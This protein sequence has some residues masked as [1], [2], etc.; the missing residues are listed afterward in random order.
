MGC[1]A[2]RVRT[3]FRSGGYD[4]RSRWIEIVVLIAGL[5]LLLAFAF[6]SQNGSLSVYST[7][8]TGPNGYEAL[9]NVLRNEGVDVTRLQVPFTLRDPKIRVLAFTSTQPEVYA[10]NALLYDA[11][12]YDRLAAFVKHGG[13]V[14]YFASPHNDPMRRRIA[15]QKLRVTVLDVTRFTNRA[16]SEDPH[17]V[18]A[19]YDALAGH[20]PVAFDER[21][22]G[23]ST[24]R[25]LWTVL[26][27]PVRAA[28]WIVVAALLI[29]LVDATIRFAPPLAVE[30]QPP[31]DSA[32]YIRSMAALLRRARAGA[33][34]ISR[35]A[36][37]A[38]QD[39]ELQQLAQLSHPKDV[40]V[41]RAAILAA[42]H[43]KEGA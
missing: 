28:F 31:R 30:P 5:G 37:N 4:V 42:R 8:D 26:P 41:L 9:F 29:V 17:R 20:G 15:R 19:A 6:A 1:R 34:A 10:G 25:T 40:V 38:K 33:A 7:Y 16:L 23:F 11:N 36:K 27:L 13:R 35:F 3:S 18:V 43:R 32:A 2:G 12:D 21:L 22:H 14:V 39:E 24:Q